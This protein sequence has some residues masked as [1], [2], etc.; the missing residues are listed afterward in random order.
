MNVLGK[1]VALV[2]QYRAG[3]V[4]KIQPEP[5]TRAEYQM[6]MELADGTCVCVQKYVQKLH[7]MVAGCL[8]FAELREAEYKDPNAPLHMFRCISS[9]V[10]YMHGRGYIHTDISPDNIM[11]NGSDYILIDLGAAR[12][13]GRYS[14]L[15]G[16][17]HH[18]APEI[19]GGWGPPVDVFA[20]TTCYMTAV[21]LPTYPH[22]Y[23]LSS[24]RVL[25]P[26]AAR[27]TILWVC[28]TRAIVGIT[29]GVLYAIA[30][31][32][33]PEKNRLDAG[34]LRALVYAQ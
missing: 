2:V 19:P 10:S 4:M 31:S 30:G 8:V 34:Q 25:R 15:V 14:G 1:S 26:A 7:M 13:A 24:W 11:Y 9:A 5:R 32:M 6:L 22:D 20:T 28:Y 12:P 18:R 21:G 16:K 17:P 29:P 27:M 33:L 3:L 23:G